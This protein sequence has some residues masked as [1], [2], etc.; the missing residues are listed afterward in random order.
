MRNEDISQFGQTLRGRLIT[1]SDPD[2]DEARTLYNGMIDKRP[3][4]I[5]HCVDVA[6]VIAAV[7]FG[8]DN[9]LLIAIRGGG[10][11]GPG[12]GSVRRRAGHRP[13]DDERRAGRPGDQHRSRRAGLH[14]GGCRPRDARLRP[15]GPLRHRL[16]HRRRWPDA[17]RRIGLPDAQI[18]A[19][20]R[21]SPRSRRGARR[22]QLRYREQEGE[23]GSLLGAPRRRR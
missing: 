2:Y 7:N 18:R 16:D 22:R 13:V 17:R 15:C 6:D 11:N 19:D 10:H 4:L 20:H 12:L 8:R 3:L 23:S 5:A 1:R 21:Q 9:G 14:V